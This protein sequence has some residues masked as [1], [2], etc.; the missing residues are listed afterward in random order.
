MA[1]ALGLSACEATYQ[2]S[3]PVDSSL[4]AAE[5]DLRA[6][7]AAMQKTVTEAIVLGGVAGLA[8]R[9][10]LE[11][12]SN[13]VVNVGYG[14]FF[15]FGAGAGALA[16]TYVAHLQN[17]FSS[18][19]TQIAALRADIAANASETRATLQVMRVVVANQ[20]QE[21]RL[22]QQ[23]VNAGTADSAALAQEIAQARANL[24]EMDSAADGATGRFNEFTD[25][26]MATGGG[27]SSIE[28][29]LTQLSRQ[30]EQMRKIAK[31]L[32]GQL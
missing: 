27:S 20:M 22:V 7:S 24:A 9:L 10:L 12:S 17:N 2:A 16:G 25:A 15:T 18:Q 1:F 30:I 31:N 3:A 14:G 4:S 23:A 13:R 21:L 32:A 26:R 6:R 8:A 29:E 28:S 5:I 19:E 11:A